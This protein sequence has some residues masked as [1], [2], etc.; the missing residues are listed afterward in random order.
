MNKRKLF[1][2]LTAVIMLILTACSGSFSDPGMN[3]AAG[4]GSS[5]GTTGGGGW[6]SGGSGGGWSGGSGGG[7]G[8]TF[9]LTGIPSKYNGKYAGASCGDSGDPPLV[10]FQSMNMSK[11]TGTFS[12]ISNGRVSIPLWTVNKNPTN[13]NNIY[14][15]YSGNDTY[16]PFGVIIYNSADVTTPDSSAGVTFESVTFSNGSA[17]RSWDQGDFSDF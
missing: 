6:G 8:G 12:R 15:R 14:V 9:T 16:E 1:F 5:G 10:G 11:G 13:L 3:D 17:T 4:G 2:I 7:S